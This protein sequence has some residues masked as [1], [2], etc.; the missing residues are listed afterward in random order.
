MEA[1]AIA[2]ALKFVPLILPTVLTWAGARWDQLVRSRVKNEKIRNALLHVD[3][4]ILPAV[5]AVQQVYVDAIA[6][7][8][9][10]GVLTKEEKKQALTMAIDKAKTLIPPPILLVLEG[11]YGKK[12]NEFLETKIEAA[13]AARKKLQKLMPEKSSW[14]EAAEKAAAGVSKR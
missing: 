12:L 11:L 5:D 1:A 10:D 2:L 9:A 6:K 4:A 7:A 8:N 13:V 14:M 3:D